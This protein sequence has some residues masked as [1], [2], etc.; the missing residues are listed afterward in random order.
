[1]QQIDEGVESA[2]TGTAAAHHH[3]I[4]I[5][6]V[7]SAIQTHADML[8]ENLVGFRVF[9]LLL[10]VDGGSAAPFGRAVFLTTAI[11][12]SGG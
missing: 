12:A 3:S 9:R 8:G 11:V 7:L 5:A 1:M 10:L 2:L 6:A 4:Q